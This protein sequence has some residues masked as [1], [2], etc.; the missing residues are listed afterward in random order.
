MEKS[1]MESLSDACSG[2]GHEYFCEFGVDGEMRCLFV[3]VTEQVSPFSL[4]LS[5]SLSL[6][7]D[8]V[9]MTELCNLYSRY[10]A[11]THKHA[12]T[13][14]RTRA[15]THTHTHTRTHARTRFLTP[16]ISLYV[17]TDRQT[18]TYLCSSSLPF[19]LI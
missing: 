6:S 1:C 18:Q 13:H 11:F 12:R 7:R 4:S 14:A 16:L 19:S 17:Q 5:L 15:H 8:K 2:R 3:V 10:L 9:Y